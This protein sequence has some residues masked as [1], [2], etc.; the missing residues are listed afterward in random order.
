VTSEYL[1]WAKTRKPGRYNLAGSGVLPY[2]IREL[3]PRIEDIELN[4]DSLYGYPPLQ[5][6][7][8]GHCGV[9]EDF[10]VASS[11]TS[12]AN[13]LA[14]AA[15]IEPGD[16]ILVEDPVYEPLLAA[17]QYFGGSIRRLKRRPESN[18][19][20]PPPNDVIS[21]KTK[22]IIIT[23]LHNPTS[24]AVS[25]KTLREY[26]EVARGAGA[27]VLVDEVYLECMYEKFSSAAQYGREF[28]ITG[29]LTKAYGLGGLRCGWVVADPVLVQRMWRIKDLID[30]SAPHPAEL[31][32][33][34]AFR[35][36]K[37]IGEGAK[38][39]LARNRLLLKEFLFECDRLECV[40]PGFG[41]CIFPR[42]QGGDAEQFVE[43]LHERYDTDVVPGRF[44]EMP[45]HFRLGIGGD[46]EML[47]AGLQ[48]LKEAL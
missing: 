33:V 47:E 17:V 10:V 32:S 4:A 35:K 36:L 24:L 16:E 44:F 26:G 11:G 30:P 42:L 20:L 48:R 27:R 8:A 14:L 19:Q 6:A 1:A 45:D 39:L 31:L 34:I 2:T 38:A 21:S 41:T 13:F 12:M 43:I 15:L 23:N 28:V 46:T 40:L 22:L 18:F 7:I 9:S 37:Q 29:S 3:K 25:E 5:A